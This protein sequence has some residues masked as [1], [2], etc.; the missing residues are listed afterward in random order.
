MYIVTLH[1][2][3]GSIKNH[4][5]GWS[6]YRDANPVPNSQLADDLATF[7][8][9]ALCVCILAYLSVFGWMDERD[10]YRKGRLQEY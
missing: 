2:L 7:N 9:F 6:W 1:L 10:E 8:E 3:I 4:L 5:L